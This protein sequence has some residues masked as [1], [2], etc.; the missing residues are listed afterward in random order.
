MDNQSIDLALGTIINFDAP[1]TAQFLSMEDV[2]LSECEDFWM[3]QLSGDNLLRTFC[4]ELPVIEVTPSSN[5]TPEGTQPTNFVEGSSELPYCAGSRPSES[6]AIVSNI[7]NQ[8]IVPI[9]S[10][11]SD[12]ETS[13]QSVNIVDPSAHSESPMVGKV[14]EK[15]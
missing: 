10:E 12:T 8:I 11:M 5:T 13:E 15:R 7:L 2:L 1:A 14:N 6:S 4:I 9:S 3:D